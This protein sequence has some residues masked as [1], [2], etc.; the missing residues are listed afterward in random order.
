MAAALSHHV[1]PDRLRKISASI[2]KVVIITGD[3]DNM[4]NTSN[5]QLLKKHMPEAEFILK[6][7][8]GHGLTMQYRAWFNEVLERVF[9]EGREKATLEQH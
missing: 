1:T 9:K 2:P 8:G 6:E 3:S 4:V 7:G 5:S